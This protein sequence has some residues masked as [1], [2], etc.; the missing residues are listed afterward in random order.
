M[1]IEVLSRS[2]QSQEVS[3]WYPNHNQVVPE[4]F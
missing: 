4:I 3:E 1:G 2:H